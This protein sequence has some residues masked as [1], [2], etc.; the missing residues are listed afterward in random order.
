MKYFILLYSVLLMHNS[1]AV[2]Q[3][4]FIKGD[5]KVN[6]TIIQKGHSLKVGDEVITG[7]DS[8]AIIKIDNKAII[9]MSEQSS[10]V[11]STLVE[12]DKPISLVL[13]AGSLFSKVLEKA[14]H[15]KSNFNIHAKSAIMGVRG[16]EFFTAYSLTDK[17]TSDDL[18]MCVN[19]GIVQISN[20]QTKELVE[21]KEGEGVFIKKGYESSKPKP[22]AWTKKLNWNLDPSKGDLKNAALDDLY[23]DL[24][25]Q[26][27]D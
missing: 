7:P 22:Y 6:Q 20:T 24:L 11:I 4:F 12:K 14:P 26:D 5:V 10:L 8:L 25:D 15:G 21:V 27:Y 1:F 18:W 3:L 23:S 2:T 9:K 19:E 13:K 17:T 16:T